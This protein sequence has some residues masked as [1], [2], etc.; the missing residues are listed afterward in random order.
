MQDYPDNVLRLALLSWVAAELA[1]GL[2]PFWRG[3]TIVHAPKDW[4]A[5]SRSAYLAACG[6]PARSVVYRCTTSPIVACSWPRHMAELAS[7][8]VILPD[9]RSEA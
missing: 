8:V 5:A 9:A 4:H 3:S 6:N 2:D 1:G 7:T